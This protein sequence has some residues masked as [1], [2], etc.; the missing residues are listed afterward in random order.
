MATIIPMQ[1]SLAKGMGRMGEAGGSA[2]YEYPYPPVG[3]PRGS[4]ALLKFGGG[5]FTG[6]A[7]GVPGE[8]A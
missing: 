1:L 4:S 8:V 3:D 2:P 5:R 6:E 7:G